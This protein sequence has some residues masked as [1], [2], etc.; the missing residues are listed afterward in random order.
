MKVNYLDDFECVCIRDYKID[1]KKIF[2]KGKKYSGFVVYQTDGCFNIV[3]EYSIYAEKIYVFN[4][5][6]F[7]YYF[8]GYDLFGGF[9]TS[10]ISKIKS[11]IK[12]GIGDTKTLPQEDDLGRCGWHQSEFFEVVKNDTVDNIE[13]KVEEFQNMWAKLSTK[14]EK[15]LE[16]LK[17]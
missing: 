7:L 3:E 16:K 5:E 9:E 14:L 6:R 13:K 15:I 11:E 12:L 8:K 1:D 10:K 4:K 2:K 17:K